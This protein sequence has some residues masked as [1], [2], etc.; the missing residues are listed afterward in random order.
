[1]RG[2]TVLLSL[3]LLLAVSC[4]GRKETL[5]PDRADQIITHQVQYGE[6]WVTIA[7]DF[8]GDDSRAGDLALYNGV[9]PERLPEP[10]SGVRIPLEKKD[11]RKLRSKLD[12]ADIYND[13]LDLVSIGD[14]AGAIDK[15]RS[16]LEM[17]PG[18]REASFNLAVTF[19]ELGLHD[20]ASTVLEGLVTREPGNPDYLF[21]LGH[22][23]FHVG[24]LQGAE[25]AFLDALEIDSNHLKAL[26][27][28]ATVYEKMGELEKAANR[29]T[30]YIIREPDGEWSAEARERLERVNR[31]REKKH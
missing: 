20:R 8:Y 31:A 3:A 18:L 25:G 17:D 29:L 10:G 13:G 19:Q 30:E 14:Y 27:S 2:S 22:A 26:F 16:A 11:V 1:M 6:T 15:F 24:D 4:A 21:A 28:L 5:R 23:Y 12:A 7:E 9:D